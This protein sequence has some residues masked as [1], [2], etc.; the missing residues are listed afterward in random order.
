MG[1]ENSNVRRL[2]G[3]R[4]ALF[5]RLLLWLTALNIW[6]IRKTRGRIGARLGGLPVLLLQTRGRSSG[7]PRTAALIYLTTDRGYVVIGSQGGL[8]DHPHW[9]RNLLAHPAATVILDAREVAV[10]ARTAS[11]EER[12]RLWKAALE[13]W[14]PYADYQAR[15]TRNIPVLILSPG[16]A[17][18]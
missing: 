11:G 12:A 3:P 13:M 14:P 2:T 16:S 17:E 18:A 8:P 5:R 4:A 6:L 7:Q 15:T 9:Y 10:R 1:S